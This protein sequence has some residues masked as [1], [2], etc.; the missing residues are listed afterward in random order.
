MARSRMGRSVSPSPGRRP[1]AQ[2]AR[3][4]FLASDRYRV[5]REWKRYEGTAQRDLFRV[6]RERF[7]QRNLAPTPTW[8]LDIGCG[9]GR[10]TRG[11]SGRGA[12]VI[13]LD[14][15]TRALAFLAE[16]WPVGPAAPNLPDRVRA[17]AVAPPFRTGSFGT[18]VL[19]GNTLGFAAENSEA[20]LRSAG[21]LVAPAGRLLMEIA[22][23]PGEYSRYLTRLPTGSM[24]RLLRA[25][26]AAVLPRI[27]REGFRALPARKSIPGPFRRIR[28]PEALEGFRSEEWKVLESMAVGP[29]LGSEADRLS[30]VREDG[31]AWGRL[32]ELEEELG[33]RPDRWVAAASVLLAI[34]RK[35]MDNTIN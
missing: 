21:S 12:R 26:T 18:V 5:E 33:R 2:S 34:E 6:L 32:L 1:A 27:E 9:P 4:R 23:G 13:A 10:F 30:A 25:P 19:F 28:V 11:L 3:E 7:L 16:S 29:A 24:V 14:L 15:S 35:P 31:K 8:A 22:P 20:V 17:D